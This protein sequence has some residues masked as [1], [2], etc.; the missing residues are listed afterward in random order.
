MVKPIEEF[1]AAGV[2][3]PSD[4]DA[5]GRLELLRWLDEYGF[6]I[7]EMEEGLATDSLGSMVGDRRLVPGRR[8]TRAEALEVA[9]IESTSFDENVTAFGFRAIN[10][11]PPGEVGITAEEAE[12]LGAFDALDVRYE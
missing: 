10:G 5:E 7:A 9:G 8:L 11:A 6:T 2:Y 3:D 1:I 4:V 12:V